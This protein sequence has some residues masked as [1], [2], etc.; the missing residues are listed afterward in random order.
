MLNR[1]YRTQGWLTLLRGRFLVARLRERLRTRGTAFDDARL[2]EWHVEVW[3]EAA[4]A[5][6]A[7]FATLGDGFCEARRGGVVTRMWKQHVMLDDP[8]TL[9]LAGNKPLVHRLLLEAGL[10]VPAHRRFRL[11]NIA[12]ALEFLSQQDAAC[13]VKP[14]RGTGAGAGVTTGVRTP[15]DLCR[16]AAL[17]ASHAGELLIERQVPG[18]SYR[19]LF[20]DGELIDAIRRPAPHVVGDG[21][22]S[23][24]ALVQAENQR[25]LQDGRR[26]AA[27]PLVVDLDCR[28]TL[29][30]AGLSMGS[31]PAAGQRVVVKEVCNQAGDADNE[32]VRS[33]V[34]PALVRQGAAAAAAVG[35]RLA[36]IDVIT[37][38]PSVALEQSGGVINEVNTTPGL[39]Y[40]YLVRNQ[41]QHTPVAVP[42][43]RAVL[44]SLERARAADE[45]AQV[46]ALAAPAA[47]ERRAAP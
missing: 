13:V 19:L 29:R 10:P 35:A 44:H 4:Q 1:L 11:R 9:A 22:S 23:I 38:D 47:G 40:H 28:L 3:R 21:R 37:V 12:A 8:V 14:A 36:G 31:V 7:E 34:G 32:A 24:A 33:L 27:G 5:A 42:I 16:A 30:A 25:R 18:S 6:G 17:A 46:A 39:R 45:S 26:S 15:R 43:L 2:T 41:E 20:L